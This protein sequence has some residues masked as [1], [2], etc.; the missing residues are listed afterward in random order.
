[1]SDDGRPVGQ[2]PGTKDLRSAI[3]RARL[4]EAERSDVIID[5]RAAELA[6]LELLA[7]ELEPVIE[8]LPPGS[9]LIDCQIVPGHQ[10]RL[11]ID[12]LGYV[13]MACD[14]H[15]YE[16]VSETREGSQT[17]FHS[18]DVA[19]MAGKVTDYIAHRLI[20][21][22]RLAARNSVPFGLQ[23]P[24]LDEPAPRAPQTLAAPSPGRRPGKTPDSA[25]VATA[26]QSS[27]VA[28]A[29]FWRLAFA[30][31]LG[32]VAGVVGLLVLGLIVT[33]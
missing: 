27:A 26:P 5:L 22:D 19:P 2:G 13:Q 29:G 17:L 24:E 18:E 6:R 3:R 15:G 10:P 32:L 25:A 1:M 11:W 7:E 9:E 16:L 23:A 14:K 8:Q 4:S 21:R 20:E 12:M 30:F 33:G 31:M 28:E